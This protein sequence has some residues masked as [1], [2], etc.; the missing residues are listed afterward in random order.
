VTLRVGKLGDGEGCNGIILGVVG[1]VG[2]KVILGVV[3]VVGV[4]LR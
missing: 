2:V 1:V 3:G 4:G